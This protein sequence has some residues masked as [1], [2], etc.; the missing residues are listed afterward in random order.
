[1]GPRKQGYIQQK[2]ELISLKNT[3]NFQ[4]CVIKVASIGIPPYVILITKETE[5]GNTVYDIR[6][7]MIEYFLLSMKKMNMTM[8]F[9]N[10]HW[11]FR[12]LQV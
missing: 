6:G 2:K 12:L 10:L 8:N 3:K 4:N 7:L 1:M 9:F 11:T 5:D